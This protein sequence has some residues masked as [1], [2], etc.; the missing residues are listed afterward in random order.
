[1]YVQFMS[2][3]YG[4]E[5]LKILQDC[6]FYNVFILSFDS[7]FIFGFLIPLEICCIWILAL[8][9][10]S[11]SYKYFHKVIYGMVILRYFRNF[12]EQ[13]FCANPLFYLGIKPKPW[14]FSMMFYC[15]NP[16]YLQFDWLKKRAYF[17]K[18]QSL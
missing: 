11:L 13:A 2:C 9:T 8:F 18:F 12:F 16:K 6:F 10:K 5:T 1:M 14:I 3:V 15:W 4:V 17:W 7:I